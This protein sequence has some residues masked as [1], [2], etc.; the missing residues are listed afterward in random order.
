MKPILKIAAIALAILLVILIAIPFLI[1]VNRFRPQIEAQLSTCLGPTGDRGESQPVA[2]FGQRQG[3]QHR[4]RRR[5]CLQQVP[6]HHGEFA[7]GGGGTAAPHP[8]EAAQRDR[9]Y[10]RAAGDHAAQKRQ[11]KM[12]LFKHR[13]RFDREPAE[14]RRHIADEFLG[15]QAEGDQWEVD[16]RPREFFRQTAGL[17]QAGYWDDEFLLYH[18]VPVP[19]FGAAAGGR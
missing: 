15:G 5:S 2:P 6:V 19:T 13:R 14:V 4:H 7:E 16:C 3:R 11:R 1:D 18:P 17:R 8:V 9:D 12:E 10:S